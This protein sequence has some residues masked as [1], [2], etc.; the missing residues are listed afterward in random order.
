MNWF[1]PCL[2]SARK[3][4]R[5]AYEDWRESAHAAMNKRGI[6]AK[7]HMNVALGKFTGE[8]VAKK[9]LDVCR[10]EMKG[11]LTAGTMQQDVSSVKKKV[12]GLK[13]TLQGCKTTEEKLEHLKD[14]FVD[15]ECFILSC[16]PSLK[17]DY[18]KGELKRK[19][20]DRLVLGVKQAYEYLDDTVDFHFWNCANLPKPNRFGKYYD[21]NKAMYKPI[22]VASSNYSVGQRWSLR[23]EFDLFFKVPLRTEIDDQ[24]L[25]KTYDFEKY[26]LSNQAQRPCAPGIML[27]TVIYMA[28]HLGCKKINV[29]G[30]DLS[31]ATSNVDEHKHFYGETKELFNRGDVLDWEIQANIDASGPLY[32]WLRAKGVELNILSSTSKLDGSIPRAKL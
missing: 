15:D 2:L 29:L 27:E 18:T 13:K 14:S 23:Q 24:F 11:N 20:S 5:T 21:Y 25:T 1:E 4:L 16:G 17:Q 7:D 30:W 8:A 31:N 19:L 10:D 28:V 32:E 9:F 22:I 26:L 12:S 6:K 3:Q